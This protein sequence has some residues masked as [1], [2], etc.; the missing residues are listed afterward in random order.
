M[1]SRSGEHQ[2]RGSSV[3]ALGQGEEQG[4]FQL[5]PAL[6]AELLTPSTV[7]AP[8]MHPRLHCFPHHHPRLDPGD[9]GDGADGGATSEVPQHQAGFAAQKGSLLGWVSSKNPCCLQGCFWGGLAQQTAL[10]SLQSCRFVR[11]SCQILAS[12]TTRKLEQEVCGS[13][14]ECHHRLPISAASL[15]YLGETEAAAPVLLWLQAG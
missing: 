6:G 3:P 8:S 11:G 4:S 15:G 2:D 5:A 12:G 9:E 1:G 7:L 14:L 10:L 13:S